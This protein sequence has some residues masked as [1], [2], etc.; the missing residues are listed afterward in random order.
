MD[1]LRRYNT[2]EQPISI[3]LQRMEHIYQ[4]AEGQVDDPHRHDYYTVIWVRSGEGQHLID[5]NSYPLTPNSVFFVSPGQI[6][7]M[8]TLSEPVG[9]VITFSR[10]FLQHQHLSE[11]F[12]ERIKLFNAFEESPPLTLP[13]H[14]AKKLQA[15]FLMM[16]ADYQSPGELQI[17]LMSAYLKIF[18]IH[19]VNICDKGDQDLRDD[20]GGS[21]LLKR[22]KSLLKEHFR[23]QH[24]VAAYAEQLAITP[25]YLNQVVKLFLGQTAKEVIQ[26]KI[27]LNA[28]RELK[29]TDQS[30]KE[31]AYDLG[32]EDPL[33]FSQFFKKC[34][35]VSP[36]KFRNS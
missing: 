14:L 1:N 33:Y 15:I 22:F 4:L 6:H 25:K 9:W 36:S 34:T 19:C 10:A 29:Y 8:T 3:R 30:I 20:Q 35:G 16:E 11:D 13:P 5:F 23:Q 12:I 32:F 24:K 17:G 2:T 28:K 31:I 18:L 21:A 27:T 26:E 7:Q